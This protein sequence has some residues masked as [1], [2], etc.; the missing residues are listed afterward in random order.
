MLCIMIR[1]GPVSK[2]LQ[3]VITFGDW[4]N[5]RDYLSGARVLLSRQICLHYSNLCFHGKGRE[6]WLS[7]N[8]VFR[9]H[10]LVVCASFRPHGS[11]SSLK[12]L[13]TWTG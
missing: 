12:T 13:Y 9:L 3:G 8:G 5:A 7:I 11:S 4:R 1:C 10:I 6:W 2:K